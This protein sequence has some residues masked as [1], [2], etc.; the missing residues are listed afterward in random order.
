VEFIPATARRY[1]EAA[2]ELALERGELDRWAEDLR[3]LAEALAEPQ[4][5]AFLASAKVPE[6]EKERV[7][8]QALAGIGP[9]ALNLVRLLLGRGRLGLAPQISAAF[10]ERLNEHRGVARAFVTTAVPLDVARQEAIASGLGEL[11]GKQVIVEAEEDPT[12][13]GG[14]V[15]RIGDRLIDGST[16]AKLSALKRELEGSR[17]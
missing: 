2:F 9:L 5:L 1:A 12:I 4:V 6:H 8:E 14:L 7:L 13:I 15:A 3:A 17:R 10:E 16:R 11:T